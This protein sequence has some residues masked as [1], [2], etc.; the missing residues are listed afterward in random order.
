MASVP[1]VNSNIP[2]LQQIQT[3]LVPPM[4]NL[5]T[6]YNTQ[7]VSSSSCGVFSTSS[8][9]PTQVTSLT[10]NFTTIGRPIR[11]EFFPDGSSN[12]G[13][14]SVSKVSGSASLFLAFL[15]IQRD[16]TSIANFEFGIAGSSFPGNFLPPSAISFVDDAAPPGPHVYKTLLSVNASGVTATANYLVMRL[17]QD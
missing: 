17:S 13:Y 5:L 8:S 4:N 3:N 14:W 16:G 7:P 1:T 10:G 9:T 11:I 6:Q 15:T 12:P 2:A